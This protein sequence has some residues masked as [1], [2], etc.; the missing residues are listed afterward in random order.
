MFEVSNRKAATAISTIFLLAVAIGITF[1]FYYSPRLFVTDYSTTYG[2]YTIFVRDKTYHAQSRLAGEIEC[3]GADASEI[4]NYAL[5][6]LADIGGKVLLTAG[7]YTIERSLIVYSNTILEGEG[8]DDKNK[9]G[10]GTRLSAA[11]SLREPVIR[12]HDPAKGDYNIIIKNLAVDGNR[13]NKTRV[14]G[15]TGINFT[16]TIRCRIIDVAVYNCRD[17]GIVLDG[18]Q[19]TVEA[20]LDRVTS[21]GNNYRGI[22][23]RTQSD[24]H[25]QNCEVGSNEENGIVL[26]SC[27]AGSIIGCNVYLNRQSGIQLYNSKYMRIIGNRANHNGRSGIEVVASSFGWGDWN[28]LIGN[29]CYDNGQLFGDESGI[30]IRPD[31]AS[32]SNCVVEGNTCFDDQ[33]SRTQDYG[34][35]EHE[36]GDYNVLTSNICRNNNE[37][38]I[39]VSG[40]NTQVHLC[41]NGTSWIG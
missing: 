18:N 2:T 27:S 3:A 29:E 36:G 9:Q 7:N 39:K 40:L 38:D 23:L 6:A 19:G 30:S 25:I 28:T 31:G 12:N 13:S 1:L 32:V 11:R 33:D 21:R 17:T 20:Q 34:I 41:F 35:R 22:H 8:M 4:I 16:K 10:L 15:A 5:G 14:A 37:A 26:A 24:F